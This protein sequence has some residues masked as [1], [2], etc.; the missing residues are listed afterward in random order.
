MDGLVFEALTIK[1]ISYGKRRK[2]KKSC[3]FD[4]ERI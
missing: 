1:T 3:D 4:G 2:R